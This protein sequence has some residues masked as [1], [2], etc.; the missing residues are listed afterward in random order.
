MNRRFPLWIA[1]I[2]LTAGVCTL[3]RA[4]DNSP[5]ANPPQTDAW[6]SRG[7][8]AW[9]LG[10]YSNV[11][12]DPEAMAIAAVYGADDLMQTQT[13]QQQADY[14]NKLLFNTK[15]R[16]VQRAIRMRLVKIYKDSNRPDEALDQLQELINEPE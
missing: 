5:P 8:Y 6:Q 12:K 2:A 15:S 4:D 11:A 1:S 10:Q 7:S 3:L 16:A 9:A 13:P 14:F